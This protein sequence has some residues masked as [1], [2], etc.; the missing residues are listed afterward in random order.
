ME[1]SNVRLGCTFLKGRFPKLLAGSAN[2]PKGLN[3][4]NGQATVTADQF[5]E[6]QKSSPYRRGDIFKITSAKRPMA[7]QPVQVV[8]GPLST[9][10]GDPSIV[11]SATG[12]PEVPLPSN[13]SSAEELMNS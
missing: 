11:P 5:E 13:I 8:K 7:S 3:F 12:R 9:G 1:K 6:V 2:F 4:V 10:T